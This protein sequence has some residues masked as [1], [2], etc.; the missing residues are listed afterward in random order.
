MDQIK[1]KQCHFDEHRF[2]TSLMQI[3]PI[4]QRLLVSTVQNSVDYIEISTTFLNNILQKV[5]FCLKSLGWLKLSLLPC[6][7]NFGF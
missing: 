6:L 4:S 7:N 1:S 2:S 3:L 5:P